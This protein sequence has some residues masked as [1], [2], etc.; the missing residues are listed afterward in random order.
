ML[1]EY[2]DYDNIVVKFV[3][4]QENAADSLTKP[5]PSGKYGSL[6]QIMQGTGINHLGSEVDPMAKKRRK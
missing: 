5:L 1:R 6:Y 4:G 2:A 3:P